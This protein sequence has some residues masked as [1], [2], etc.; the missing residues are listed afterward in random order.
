MADVQSMH[1]DRSRVAWRARSVII[2][3]EP[4]CRPGERR[5]IA[6][7]VEGLP[8]GPHVDLNSVGVGHRTADSENLHLV[9][10][11]RQSVDRHRRYRNVAA[12]RPRRRRI[13]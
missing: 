13:G 4:G 6:H 2:G 9:H 3:I 5:R 12:G 1:D 8:V 11:R 10:V 7:E